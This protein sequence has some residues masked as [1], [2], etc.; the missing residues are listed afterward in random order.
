MDCSPPGSSVHGDSPGK[1]TGVGCH[2]VLQ[3][4]FPTQGSNPGLLCC[5]PI[6]YC[7]SHQG[8]PF[9]MNIQGWFPLGL[10]VFISLLS[11]GLSRVFSSTTLQ[12]H[13]FFGAQP[14]LWSN[15]HNRTWLLEKPEL[16]IPTFVS[17]V[18]ALLF[19]MLSRFVIAFLSRS[20]HLLVSWLQSPSAV[21]LQHK[22]INLSLFPFVPHLFAMKWWD[23]MPWS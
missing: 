22:K 6:L 2:A 18:M 10:T 7:L 5:R 15:S 21:N 19:N 13:Q 4:I 8:S 9:P 11:K 23:W 20:K 14:S 12:K 3:G 1:N 17:K 16:T